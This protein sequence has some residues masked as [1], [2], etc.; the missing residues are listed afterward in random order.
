MCLAGYRLGGKSKE[1]DDMYIVCLIL[2]LNNASF[3]TP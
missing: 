2:F 1:K 3:K